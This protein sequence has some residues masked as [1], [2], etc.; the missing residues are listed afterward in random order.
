MWANLFMILVP[1]NKT[2]TLVFLFLPV[3]AYAQSFTGSV[4]DSQSMAPLP[5]ASIGVRGKGIGGIADING[6]FL[7]DM[8]KALPTDTIIIS[9]LGYQSKTLVKRDVS[10]AAY[11]IELVSSPFQLKEV[12]TV[13]KPEIISIGNKKASGYY[14]GWGDYSSSKGRLRGTTIETDE[15]P[16]KLIRF[17]LHLDACEFD[18]VRFRLHILPLQANHSGNLTTELLH[19]NIFFTAHKDQK[20]VSVDLTFYNL[21]IRQ[22][23]I[24]G[25]E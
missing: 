7:I 20:W 6:H 9:Y 22:N 16:L 17:K 21:I 25:V 1:L 23:I 5:Y 18:S 15:L 4:T 11:R 2:S 19:E 24:V 14:T 3:L 8:T 10:N 12:V 13:G